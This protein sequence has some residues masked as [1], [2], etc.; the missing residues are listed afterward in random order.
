LSVSGFELLSFQ[1]VAYLLYQLTAHSKL[2]I[3]DIIKCVFQGTRA[4]WVYARATASQNYRGQHFCFLI[5]W[6]LVWIVHT[7]LKF[8]VVP[9]SRCWN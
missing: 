6:P 5:T 7:L 9:P 8:I 3:V 1:P 4:V 2:L